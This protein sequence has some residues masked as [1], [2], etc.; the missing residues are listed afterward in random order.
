[1]S[2]QASDESALIAKSPCLPLR[3]SVGRML[4]AASW[5]IIDRRACWQQ[6]V[7]EGIMVTVGHAGV[8]GE[9]AK[10]YQYFSGKRNSD[11]R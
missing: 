5:Q 6:V 1:L 8:G 9:W 10:A 11:M 2:G 7:E 3:G 4:D